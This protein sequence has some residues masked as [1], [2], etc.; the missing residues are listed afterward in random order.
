MSVGR[1][2]VAPFQTLKLRDWL[3]PKTFTVLQLSCDTD[4]NAAF[5]A[6]V[7]EI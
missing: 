2:S 6:I 4:V 5:A 7:S 3:G 1:I